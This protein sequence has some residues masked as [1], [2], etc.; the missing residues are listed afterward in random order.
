M[1]DIFSTSTQPE[2]MFTDSPANGGQAGK[3]TRKKRT[4]RK[5]PASS[6]AGEQAAPVANPPVAPKKR[7]RPA[8]ANTPDAETSKRRKIATSP[9]PSE[10][11][12]DTNK[13]LGAV[14]GL[15]SAETQFVASVLMALQGNGKKSRAKITAALGRIFG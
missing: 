14:I 5:T 3:K 11:Q 12:I 9:T 1:S 8:K 6:A 4:A 10:A 2:P 7:G 13:L 15:D